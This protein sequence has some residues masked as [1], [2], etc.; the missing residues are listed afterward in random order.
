[1][2]LPTPVAPQCVHP[3]AK[4]PRWSSF[5]AI[6]AIP[7][8]ILGA[9]IWKFGVD[10]PYYDH[11]LAMAPMFKKW[12]EGT[13]GISDFFAQNNEHRL[14]VPR[15]VFL[16]LGLLTKWNTRAEM[17]ATWT[18]LILLA[19]SVWRLLVATGWRASRGTHALFACI[20]LLQF[21]LLQ[22]ENL[23]WGFTFHFVVP[24]LF[25]L[26]SIVAAVRLPAPRNFLATAI[27]CTA[28]TYSIASGFT[29]WLLTAPLLML[30]RARGLAPEMR[31]WMLLWFVGFAVSFGCYFIGYEHPAHH[32]VPEDTLR[33]LGAAARYWVAYVGG[34]FAS[35][36]ATRA[37]ML[38]TLAG[39]TIFATFVAAL[40]GLWRW[41]A[42]R[43]FLE[44]A[45]PWAMV[46]AIGFVNA[47]IVAVG[48]AGFG[49]YQA[50]ASRY[51]TYSIM[52]TIGLAPLA[53]L[54]LRRWKLDHPSSH[55]RKAVSIAA[56]IAA[57]ALMAIHLAADSRALPRW[58]RFSHM[59]HTGKSLLTTIN[60]VD[61]T[62]L[63][64][65][66]LWMRPKEIPELAAAMDRMGF[67]RPALL[68][69]RDVSE[70]AASPAAPG[71]MQIHGITKADE[72]VLG[73]W[74]VLPDS[75]RVADAVFVTC[76]DEKHRPMLLAVADVHLLS[77]EGLA[78]TMDTDLAECG[79]IK[80]VPL[81]KLGDRKGTIRAWAYDADRCRAYPV[82]GAEFKP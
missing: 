57:A 14:P 60:V 53:I 26:A 80:A 49:P 27:L 24:L 52:A 40:A 30:P 39:S 32:P 5:F 8:L 46:S 63:C 1:M 43:T 56:G 41:R 74:A 2:T 7:A 82:T 78:A 70:I 72:L 71:T 20:A 51:T 76:D 6:V 19:A 25:M 69:S 50:L 65:E 73:G 77:R 59:C 28:A 31:K 81:K 34:A 66:S 18:V 33:H 44:R 68:R 48:R 4:P 23:L 3:K 45:L 54:V 42:D 9:L 37:L 13:L 62:A 35:G 75:S 67:L 58:S 21:N 36:S 61:E 11:W 38:A 47:T 17:F 55:V 15:L 64:A 22:H 29:C 12:S 16:P 10:V 79:W